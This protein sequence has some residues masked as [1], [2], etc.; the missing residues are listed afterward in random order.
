MDFI[1]L[2]SFEKCYSVLR[3]LNKRDCERLLTSK[4]SIPFCIQ[5]RI[6]LLLECSRTYSLQSSLVTVAV[7][8]PSVV[9]CLKPLVLGP[10]G[11]KNIKQYK[12]TETGQ[13][14]D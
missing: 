7:A 2:C 6:L 3:N 9:F 4:R 5:L 1:I 14:E 10:A 8:A 12:P 13:Q 11:M